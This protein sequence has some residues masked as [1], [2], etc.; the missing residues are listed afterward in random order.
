MCVC[1][2]LAYL[3]TLVTNKNYI[4]DQIK[5]KLNLGMLLAIKFRIF[6]FLSNIQKM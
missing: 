6:S 3:G 4:R 5:S 2:Y 1:V